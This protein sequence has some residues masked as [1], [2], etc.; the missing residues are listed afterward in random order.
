MIILR[1]TAT[2]T[3]GGG[4][5]VHR[6]GMEM[7]HVH[8]KDDGLTSMSVT[9][10]APACAVAEL[11]LGEDLDLHG[12]VCPEELAMKAGGVFGKV[13]GASGGGA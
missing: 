1:V 11:L 3:S 4:R 7:I 6:G 10:A 5:R 2:G 8:R 12:V 9:T 13:A